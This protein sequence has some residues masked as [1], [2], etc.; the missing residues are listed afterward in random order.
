M[1][2]KKTSKIIDKVKNIFVSSKEPEEKIESI[3]S[4]MRKNASIIAGVLSATDIESSRLSETINREN[5]EEFRAELVNRFNNAPAI[6]DDMREIDK[7]LKDFA[8]I[9]KE[10]AERGEDKVFWWCGAAL[11]EGYSLRQNLR[12]EDEEFR[13]KDLMARIDQMK[14]YDN[15]IGYCKEYDGAKKAM[16]HIEAECKTGMEKRKNLANEIADYVKTNAGGVVQ[17]ELEEN[18]LQLKSIWS[19]EA[20]SLNQRYNDFI[21]NEQ[22]LCGYEIARILNDQKFNAFRAKIEE[23]ERVLSQS[24]SFRVKSLLERTA[25]IFERE[26]KEV[27][28][29][30]NLIDE[31]MQMSKKHVR[32]LDT[33]VKESEA[34]KEL[35]YQREISFEKIVDIVNQK[36]ELLDAPPSE[37][38]NLFHEVKQENLNENEQRIVAEI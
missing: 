31:M 28:E 10:A 8:K 23:C 17:K 12:E 38:W 5:E 24:H 7:Y 29:T 3:T 4:E 11:D 32:H 15:L 14:I 34:S 13:T 18:P 26:E 22:K 19:D 20:R 16:P 2:T 35:A 33:I 25:A 21:L 30:V 27:E 36:E 37:Y 6:T 9:Y 1:P